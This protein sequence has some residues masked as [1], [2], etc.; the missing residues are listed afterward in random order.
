LL[1]PPR[2]HRS[3]LASDAEL[4][5]ALGASVSAVRDRR[6]C[7][8]LLLADRIEAQL[9][10]GHWTIVTD[11]PVEAAAQ[12]RIREGSDGKPV[13]ARFE[14]Y[15]DG[16]ELANGYWELG[17][18]AELAQ[19]LESERMGRE[20]ASD[21]IHDHRFDAAMK[22]GL[23]ACAGVAVGFDRVAMLAFGLS[24]VA[25]TMAFPWQRS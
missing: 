20:N 8:D 3:I 7:L 23:T 13:A 14:V 1:C 24:S 11:Y 25:E 4:R 19:R 22:A 18:S 17:D 10:R 5:Q 21:L 9:G 12:A 16:I 15:R 6:D 2:R